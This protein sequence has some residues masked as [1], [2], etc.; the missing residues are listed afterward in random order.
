MLA[1]QIPGSKTVQRAIAVIGI[2]ITQVPVD[3]GNADRSMI[4]HDAQP[5]LALHERIGQTFQ[6]EIGLPKLL[7]AQL[8]QLLGLSPGG[9]LTL[10]P[11][12]Q[13]LQFPGH[14]RVRVNR[15]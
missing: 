5:L 4:G 12:S 3:L 13:S 11:A 2:D 1:Q 6:F 15:S 8:E 10:E 7:A 14:V 9:A